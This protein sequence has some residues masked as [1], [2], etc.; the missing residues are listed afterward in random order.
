MNRIGTLILLWVGILLLTTPAT[1]AE[2]DLTIANKGIKGG[3][4]LGSLRGDDIR[5]SNVRETFAFGAFVN[6]ALSEYFAF[7][8]ELLY[9]QKGADDYV[10]GYKQ[11]VKLS[12]IEV[13]VLLKVY[14]RGEADVSP[15][16]FFGPYIAF[17][18]KASVE[19]AS[20]ADNEE[21]DLI[22]DKSVDYGLVFGAGTDWDVEHGILSLEVRY[23]MGLSDIFE[24]TDDTTSSG[25]LR[26][27]DDMVTPL[28]AV[29]NGSF[30][31]L[32]GFGF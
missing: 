7:Q 21:I 9:S 31:V 8:P 2:L 29:H 32:V 13:P 23:S 5:G 30:M 11:V 6:L 14:Y 1:S 18:V 20:A 25:I 15:N 24:D 28:T 12:Y 22:N 4:A 19:T 27:P 16:L 17:N 26:D 10:V 3:L